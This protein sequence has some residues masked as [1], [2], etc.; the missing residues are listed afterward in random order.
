MNKARRK[1]IEDLIKSILALADS[2]EGV[3]D[4]DHDQLGEDIEDIETEEQEYF[5]NMAA[6]FQESEKG[7]AALDAV[8]QLSEAKAAIENARDLMEQALSALRDDAV[9]ALEDAKV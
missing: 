7:R 9:G 3:F 2:I 6:S 4:P 5:D 8:E 1:S